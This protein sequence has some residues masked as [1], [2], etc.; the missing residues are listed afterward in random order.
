M[1]KKYQILIV[2]RYLKSFFTI[3][4]ALTIFF[5][6]IDLVSNL[7]K[8]PQ[9]ANLK[10]LFAVNRLLYFTSFTF[11]LSLMFGLV[12]SMI[13]LIK[14][15]ELVVMYSFGA[16]KKMLL[17]PFLALIMIFIIIFWLLNNVTNYVSA[18]Q[19]ADNIRD[20]GRVSGYENN[21]FLKYSNK[22]IYISKLNKF[23]KEGEDISIYVTKGIDL[24]EVIKAKHGVFKDN[25]WLLNDV[26]IIK[27]PDIDNNILDKKLE[28][29]YKKSMK[30]LNGFKPA[31]ME[32]LYN[33]AS[34]L[35]LSDSFKALFILKDKGLSINS[36]K[37]NLYKVI[38]FPLFSIFLGII[39]FFKLPI[40]RRGS[41]LAMLSAKYYF[42]SLIIWGVLY[43]FTQISK[44]GAVLPEIG[45]ILPI[46][47]LALYSFYYYKKESATF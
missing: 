39:L 35:T 43:I 29:V 46:C 45:I 36:I 47:L 41:N 27:K 30:T 8:L 11:G 22:Y 37:A 6:G 21:L 38:F 17:K 15:N 16:S 20:Y 2:K 32:S 31:I 18:V 14:E 12:S 10:V 23:K 26:K 7:D 1:L 40:Q 5:A 19:I 33:S 44:N 4:I 42:L 28:I 34:G 9:S 24:K 13:S 3:F 25:Y